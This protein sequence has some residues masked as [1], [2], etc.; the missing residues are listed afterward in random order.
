MLGHNE[1]LMLRIK[2]KFWLLLSGLIFLAGCANKSGQ[3]T[4]SPALKVTQG[5]P[6]IPEAASILP[7][8][9]SS[10]YS[11]APDTM[12][13]V[14]ELLVNDTVYVY[15]GKEPEFPGGNVALNEFLKNNMK[16]A[17]A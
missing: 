13:V 4:G 9:T 1:L 5:T 15:V 10:N 7:T 14:E 6:E 8:D 11:V 2:D 12:K 17:K 16:L 3:E